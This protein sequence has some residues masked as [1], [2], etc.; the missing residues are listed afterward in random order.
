VEKKCRSLAIVFITMKQ[1]NEII[2]NEVK[3][4]GYGKEKHWLQIQLA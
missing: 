3:C 4:E 1:L 2:F